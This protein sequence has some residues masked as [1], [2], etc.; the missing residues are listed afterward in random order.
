MWLP[1]VVQW[2]VELNAVQRM[3]LKFPASNPG[4]GTLAVRR[5]VSNHAPHFLREKEIRLMFSSVVNMRN[6]NRPANRVTE[7]VV[8]QRRTR[9]ARRIVQRVVRLQNI[10]PEKLVCVTVIFTAAG[11]RDYRNLRT[12]RPSELRI[13][14]SA[15]HFEFFNRVDARKIQ[16]RQIRSAVNVVR[17]VQRP[18]R[19]AVPFTVKRKWNRR[20]RSR[21]QRV[22]DVKCVQL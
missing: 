14:L 1:V 18:V 16:Q 12:L 21:R 7:I 20:R 3:P 19:S 15:Q 8:T 2:P 11:L 10:V 22:A 6:P 13:V 17:A 4:V 9:D 5:T